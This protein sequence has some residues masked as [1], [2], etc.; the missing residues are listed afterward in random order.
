MSRKLLPE[1]LEKII[2]KLKNQYGEYGKKYNEGVF[3]REA[4]VERYI[5]AMKKKVD[6]QTFAYAEMLA[7]EDKKKNYEDKQEEI[8]IKTEKPFTKKVEE[9]MREMAEVL[10]KY[11][12]AFPEYDLPDEVHYLVGALSE[13]YNDSWLLLSRIIDK[14]NQ[15][16]LKEH[17]LLTGIYQKFALSVGQN[18]SFE[19]EKFIINSKK[20]GESKAYMA[21]L[22]EGAIL[23]K[24]TLNFL[25]LLTC[26]EKDENNYTKD[27]E[28]NEEKKKTVRLIIEKVGKIIED[29]RFTEFL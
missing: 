11:P 27:P 16:V 9:K 24:N 5:E 12:K 4:F 20:F 18:P 7:L 13:F 2:E 8:R 19:L 28:A 26:E 25:N 22:K 1:E 23:L 6:L 3:N 10:K 29:F 21:F 17:N 14:N 15:N